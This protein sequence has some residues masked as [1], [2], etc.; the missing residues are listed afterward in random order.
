MTIRLA[1]VLAALLIS[2]GCTNLYLEDR[3]NSYKQNAQLQQ[4]HEEPAQVDEDPAQDGKSASKSTE[5]HRKA[6]PAADI[7]RILRDLGN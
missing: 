1:T 2:A 5:D 4:I 3:G 6:D 7:R